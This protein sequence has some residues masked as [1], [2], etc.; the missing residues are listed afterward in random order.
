MTAVS[1]STNGVSLSQQV[2]QPLRTNP[3][4]FSR[5]LLN[6][7]IDAGLLLSIVLVGWTTAM[8]QVVFPAP[9]TAAGWAL[10]NLS[11]DQWRDVQ[12]IC[13]GVGALLA[14]EHLVLH[15][16]WVCSVLATQVLGLK[17]RPDEGLQAVYGVGTLIVI[18]TIMLGGIIVAI[19]TVQHPPR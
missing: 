16:N 13:L 17:S 7:W 10:W 12:S 5:T 1:E 11:Y 14:L 19:L 15:W 8:M 3:K 18:L 4:K 2:E 9:T 6:F